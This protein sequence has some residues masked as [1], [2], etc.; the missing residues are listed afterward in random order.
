[1][2]E[3]LPAELQLFPTPRKTW[4]ELDPDDVVLDR[5]EFDGSRTPDDRFTEWLSSWRPQVHAGVAA[6][7]VARDASHVVVVATRD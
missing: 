1:M 2:K 5:Y 6:V 4:L 7:Y 3:H